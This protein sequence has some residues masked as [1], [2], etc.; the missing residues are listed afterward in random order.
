M[1]W[2]Q[3]GE[4]EAP[5]PKAALQS[6]RLPVSKVYLHHTVTRITEDS[7]AD[8]RRVTDYSKYIDV[9]YTVV[10]HPNG[11]I[12]TGRYLNGV[13]ALGAHTGGHN[14]E[15]LGL[16]AIGNYVSEVPG[17]TLLESLAHVLTAWVEKGF[18]TRTFQLIGHQD[19][20]YATACPGTQLK[21]Q[22]ARILGAA[23]IGLGNVSPTPA[24]VPQ[25]PQI[26]V[27]NYPAFPAYLRKGSKGVYV[28]QIQQRLRDRG[29]NIT[30]DGDFGPATDRIIRLFQKEKGLGIDGVVGPLTWK[31]IWL[32]PVT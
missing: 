21:A 30:V 13:P 5:A 27:N 15:G 3:R 29:W 4:W 1:A 12:F 24:P 20:P 26:P 25:V 19:A 17:D 8:M 18:I 9:P 31:A 28:R 16:A 7:K 14:S 10:V 11:D 22:I 32:S 6:M 2:Y 23:T